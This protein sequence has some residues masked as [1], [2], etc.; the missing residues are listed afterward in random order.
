MNLRLVQVTAQ[1]II[2]ATQALPVDERPTER[3][4]AVMCAAYQKLLDDLAMIEITEGDDAQ[5]RRN[6]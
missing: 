3:D 6:T 1:K 2:N 5:E 4:F